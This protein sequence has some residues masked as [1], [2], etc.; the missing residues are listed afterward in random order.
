MNFERFFPKSVKQTEKEINQPTPEDS[1]NEARSVFNPEERFLQ[2]VD[3]QHEASLEKRKFDFEYQREFRDFFIKVL[4]EANIDIS[5]ML[6]SHFEV[7]S[8]DQK[9]DKMIASAYLSP[10]SFLSAAITPKYPI[11]R[12]L[13]DEELK[14]RFYEEKSKLS[15][16]AQ[17]Q[18]DPKELNELITKA[19]LEKVD[20]NKLISLMEAETDQAKKNI[21]LLIIQIIKPD[22]IPKT[23]NEVEVRRAQSAPIVGQCIMA[24]KH[25]LAYVSGKHT[26]PEG[27]HVN[28]IL[29]DDDSPLMLEKINL[30]DTHSCISLKPLRIDGVL[31]PAG[32]I[33]SAEPGTLEP[34][35]SKMRWFSKKEG[36]INY[37]TKVNNYKG[38]KF[39]RMSIL[40]VPEEIR[41]SAGGSYYLHQQDKT[42]GY[43]NYD[44]LTPEIISEYAQYRLNLDR[45]Q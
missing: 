7:P 13:L 17:V 11:E 12:L 24:E 32:A 2:H 31:I 43:I 37:V 28:L 27:G 25:M 9:A 39:V 10:T 44:W 29:D 1:V 5:D 21:L 38:F 18:R 35:R 30:G 14:K 45:K 22:A 42:K 4:E 23:D 6:K 8:D 36:G 40:S 19:Y 3:Q 34:I 33:L 15:H 41:A 20:L 16:R 26:K